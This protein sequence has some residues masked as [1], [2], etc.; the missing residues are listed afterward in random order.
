MEAEPALEVPR[1]AVLLGVRG[2][3]RRVQLDRRPLG[4]HAEPPG[5]RARLVVRGAQPLEQRGV[6]GDRLDH[7]IRSRVR[8]HLSEQRQL[9]AQP[10]QVRDALAAVGEHHSEI[11]HHPPR[12]VP[13]AA[14][15]HRAHLDR[16]VP[17]HLLHVVG[18][19]RHPQAGHRRTA[20]GA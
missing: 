9:I 16:G 6:G 2:D 12:V 10:A 20:A 7:P 5:V 15:A 4:L 19:R 17:A 3:Q 11:A 14:L 18:L 8:G 1:R 13:G